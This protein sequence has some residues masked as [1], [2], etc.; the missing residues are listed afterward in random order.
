VECGMAVDPEEEKDVENSQ[1][2]WQ[3]PTTA[4]QQQ[5]FTQWRQQSV[6]SQSQWQSNQKCQTFMINNTYRGH[7]HGSLI[8]QWLNM[9]KTLH[10]MAKALIHCNDVDVGGRRTAER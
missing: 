7:T 9:E 1:W 5:G 3:P 10:C 6:S 4:K 8:F 2:Q